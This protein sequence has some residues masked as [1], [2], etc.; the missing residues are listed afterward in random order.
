MERECA[1]GLNINDTYDREV[2]V[3]EI[4]NDIKIGILNV[5][6]TYNGGI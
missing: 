5:I 2:L 4:S 3:E 6:D 1:K